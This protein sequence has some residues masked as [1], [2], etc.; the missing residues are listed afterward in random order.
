[1]STSDELRSQLPRLA[2]EM[3]HG[4]EFALERIRAAMK[5]A[6]HTEGQT[7]LAW[8]KGLTDALLQLRPAADAQ[9]RFNRWCQDVL[10]QEVDACGLTAEERQ[11][12][13]GRPD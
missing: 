10:A 3:N 12:I 9:Q 2:A 5:L 4:I 7:G 13:T 8:K 1:M 11:N 6:D